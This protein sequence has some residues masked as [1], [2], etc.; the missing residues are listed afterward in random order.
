[1]LDVMDNTKNKR[2][3]DTERGECDTLRGADAGWQ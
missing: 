2:P 1:M 3:L